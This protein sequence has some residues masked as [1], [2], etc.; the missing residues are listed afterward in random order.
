[1]EVVTPS[2]DEKVDAD[3]SP[4]MLK[5]LLKSLDMDGKGYV[6]GEHVCRHLQ[7][8]QELPIV[9]LLVIGAMFCMSFSAAQLAK[10]TRVDD[11]GVVRVGF[12]EEA[13]TGSA[14]TTVVC[15]AETSPNRTIA[16]RQVEV[17]HK[18]SSS[19]TNVVFEN[20]DRTNPV[21]SPPGGINTAHIPI[22]WLLLS[23]SARNENTVCGTLAI[24]HLL[25][26]Y[27]TMTLDDKALRLDEAL[28]T[29]LASHELDSIIFTQ[30]QAMVMGIESKKNQSFA[31][32]PR[33][34]R[35]Q[36]PPA[37]KI[38]RSPGQEALALTDHVAQT[39]AS[40]PVL[41][42]IKIMRTKHRSDEVQSS[43]NTSSLISGNLKF[44]A[45]GHD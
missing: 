20:I 19:I 37:L 5:E 44:S 2:D 45:S 24:V 31:Y 17:G 41:I 4:S 30:S 6:N 9:M 15:T 10:D 35:F 11:D 16:T 29:Y 25:T 18:L 34:V 7:A 40:V 3:S 39:C 22:A 1:M 33:C 43:S 26:L 8:L 28:S 14:D 13:L 12:G 27:G 32:I 36:A 42:S 23:C 38:A 21:I